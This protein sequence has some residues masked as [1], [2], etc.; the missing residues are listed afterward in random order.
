[1]SERWVTVK[2]W[3]EYEVSS[4]GRVRSLERTVMRGNGIPQRIQARMLKMPPDE[5]GYPQVR[6]S[7]TKRGQKTF[8]VHVLVAK[9]FLG[10]CPADCDRV[11]HKNDVPDNNYWRNLYWGNASTNGKDSYRNGRKPADQP[12]GKDHYKYS[13]TPDL[14]KKINRL[15]AK[16]VPQTEIARTLGCNR[17]SVFDVVHGRGRHATRDSFGRS[18]P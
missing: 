1:M 9:A 11:C 3:P 13:I 17:H 2:G 7:N 14:V 18:P 4:L 12:K 8:H 10:K 15:H 5:H 6:L 16:R